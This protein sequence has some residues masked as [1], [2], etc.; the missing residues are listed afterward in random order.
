MVLDQRLLT[1]HIY[2]LISIE[3]YE[4]K[5]IMMIKIYIAIYI[6]II[7]IINTILKGCKTSITTFPVDYI[8]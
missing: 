3:E 2:F 5:I 4:K 8:R 7:I 6:I 1:F